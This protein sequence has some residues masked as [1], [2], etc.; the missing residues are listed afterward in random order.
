MD[1]VPVRRNTAPVETGHESPEAHGDA[2]RYSISDGCRLTR[3]VLDELATDTNGSP[4]ID[5]ELVL[6]AELGLRASE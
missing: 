3:L 6:V 2:V 4:A 5:A 1:V